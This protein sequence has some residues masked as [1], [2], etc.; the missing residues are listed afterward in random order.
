MQNSFQQFIEK[1]EFDNIFDQQI[2][3]ID[4]R[5]NEILCKIIRD[6]FDESP[7]I[8]NINTVDVFRIIR[9]LKKKYTLEAYEKA[10][11]EIVDK[12]KVILKNRGYEIGD[13]KYV[14][15]SSPHWN[16]NRSD[17]SG[18]VMMQNSGNFSADYR[19]SNVDIPFSVAQEMSI[20]VTLTASYDILKLKK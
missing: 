14:N 1:Y 6:G 15:D 3:N 18:I 4:P 12:S 17:S 11:Q 5:E 9:D 13:I 2:L 20:T 7:D 10:M 19:A 8:M 16:Y